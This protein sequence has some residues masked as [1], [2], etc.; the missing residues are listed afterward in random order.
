MQRSDELQNWIASLDRRA[1][2]LLVGLTLGVLGGGV[3]LM[4]ALAG[5][6]VTLAVMG[7]VLLA[8]Y[9]LTDVNVALY[10]ALAIMMLLPFGT[11]PFEIGFTPSLLDGALG[12]FVVVYL[13]QWMTGRRTT[14]RLTPV[15][16]LIALYVMWLI[17]AFVVGMQYGM[18]NATMI[19]QFAS[20]LLAIG[21]TVIVVDLL[22]ER[23]MLRRVVLIVL[24]LVGAQAA[25]AL[26][27]WVLNDV[28]AESLLIRLS[29]IGYPPGG[30]IR[31]I[32]DNPALAERAIGTWVDPNAL[33]GILATAAAMITPQLFAR[34][35]VLRWRMLTLS[36]LGVTGLA[37]LLTF[38]RASFLALGAGLVMIALLRYP[39][40]LPVLM[41]GG[42]VFLF[43][44]QTQGFIERLI[45][46]FQGADLATQMRL[47]EWRDALNLIRQ[48]PVFG[49]GFTGTPEAGL[50]TDV[51]NMYL[52]MAN[53][54]GL[55]GVAFFLVA[56]TGVFVYGWRAWRIAR[57]DADLD[58][59][60]LGYHVALMVALINSIADLYYFRTDFQASITWFWLTV[61]LCL[62]SSR[63]ILQDHQP[64]QVTVA[65]DQGLG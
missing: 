43:L 36:V 25:G 60:H 65:S 15:H 14:L 48:Y 17:F 22:R 53:Q 35:P 32:E 3:G 51:A 57:H 20:A 24:L 12:A 58:S 59:I 56:M 52:I 50:Y 49:I 30:V 21:L 46:A 64:E 38:S 34:R 63:L 23:V 4:L 27:L 1:Y 13:F 62:A 5:P 7:G 41:A 11:F 40:F 8:L 55:T 33:G 37:L 39:R 10:G 9:V 54:I 19:R 61:A 29:R 42:V 6:F 28:T 18:P 44:P 45:Q 31:Y 16:A 2:A 26:L 47:G